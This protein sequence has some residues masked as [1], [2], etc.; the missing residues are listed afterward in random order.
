MDDGSLTSIQFTVFDESAVQDPAAIASLLATT[1]Q[2]VQ[3]AKACKQQLEQDIQLV[4]HVYN[5]AVV[6]GRAS[7]RQSMIPAL[8]AK[9][10]LSHLLDRYILLLALDLLRMESCLRG[11]VPSTYWQSWNSSTME[12]R[13]RTPNIHDY[14]LWQLRVYHDDEDEDEETWQSP[15]LDVV[16]RRDAQ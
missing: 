4:E 11:P 8:T 16:L 12:L 14:Y 1:Y 5:S 15:Q 7:V 13:N 9:L 2:K 10:T 6:Y 3:L